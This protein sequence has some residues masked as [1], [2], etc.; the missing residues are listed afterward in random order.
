MPLSVLALVDEDKEITPGEDGE[1]EIGVSDRSCR[2]LLTP[3]PEGY[4]RLQ[5]RRL[6]HCRQRTGG[7]EGQGV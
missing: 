3:K 2:G 1:R 5:I 6:F 7:G 4:I